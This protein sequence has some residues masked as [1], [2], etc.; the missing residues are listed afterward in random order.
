MPQGLRVDL[1]GETLLT[2]GSKI[3]PAGG[4]RRAAIVAW[5]CSPCERPYR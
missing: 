2:R 5:P 1:L 3:I 4:P